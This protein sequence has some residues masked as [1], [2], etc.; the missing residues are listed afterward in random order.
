MPFRGIRND[1]VELAQNITHRFPLSHGGPIHTGDPAEIGI[2]DLGDNIENIGCAELAGDETAMFWACGVTAID[3]V[4]VA[5]ADLAIT[6]APS[7]MLITDR[8][9]IRVE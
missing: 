4:Q 6:H 9:A 2:H 8:L 7:H 5:A 3:A 1:Q